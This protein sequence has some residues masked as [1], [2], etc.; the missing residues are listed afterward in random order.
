MH[1]LPAGTTPTRTNGTTNCHCR[2]CDQATP[3]AT[4]PP[5][6]PQPKSRT[7]VRPNYHPDRQSQPLTPT[8]SSQ[9]RD[10]LTA[11]RGH[12]KAALLAPT[13]I[14]NQT[15]C[16]NRRHGH[17]KAAPS[18][19]TTIFHRTP[20]RSPALGPH[21]RRVGHVCDLCHH[22][23]PHLRQ[24]PCPGPSPPSRKSGLRLQPPPCAPPPTQPWGDL[25]PRAIPHANPGTI[26]TPTVCD[27]PDTAAGTLA[28]VPPE[29]AREPRNHPYAD[30]LSHTRHCLQT[31][32]SPYP[33][34]TRA[35]GLAGTR[36][37]SRS[38]QRHSGHGQ[39]LPV[40]AGIE[41]PGRWRR[42]RG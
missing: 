12:P 31:R 11:I 29:P 24:K 30:P 10:C 4:E 8:N 7:S 15:H 23:A 28:L 32:K 1:P 9:F 19:P 16:L 21:H 5:Q 38:Q 33:T 17:P 25:D 22:P 42:S 18:A 27:T 41:Q 14:V 13:A 6:L 36:T 35:I 26:P 40:N 2:P 34:T 20:D 39:A 37:P 3:T